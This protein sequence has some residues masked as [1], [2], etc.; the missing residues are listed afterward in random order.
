MNWKQAFIL[1]LIPP[2]ALKSIDRDVLLVTADGY[3]L[4]D[5]DGQHLIAE[6]N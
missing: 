1:G 5:L 3:I 2:G 6:E 4:T